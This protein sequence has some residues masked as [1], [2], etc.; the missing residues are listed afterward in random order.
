MHGQPAREDEHDFNSR[1]S[2]GRASPTRAA[3]ERDA[4]QATMADNMITKTNPLGNTSTIQENVLQIERILRADKGD[5]QRAFSPAGR[6]QDRFQNATGSSFYNQ[7]IHQQRQ[8]EQ[9]QMEELQ[10]QLMR[11]FGNTQGSDLPSVAQQILQ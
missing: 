6:T 9:T 4:S 8:Q 7:T 10:K 2:S 5:A 1:A 11:I 3:L